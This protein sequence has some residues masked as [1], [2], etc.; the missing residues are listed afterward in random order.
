M[1]RPVDCDTVRKWIFKNRDNVETEKWKLVN[2]K[3]CQR[4]GRA[5]EKI[6]CQVDEHG[7]ETV[8]NQESESEAENYREN[9]ERPLNNPSRDKVII[10]IAQPMKDLGKKYYAWLQIVECR[11]VLKWMYAYGYYLSQDETALKN[12][13]E[14]SQAYAESSLE[15]LHQCVEEE[16]QLYI[17]SEK[18]PEFN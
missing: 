15:R 9:R 11:R 16:L 2:T 10:M 18:A 1:H 5:I 12:T 6:R 7:T 4:C 17:A 14:H 8:P 3:P 13:F